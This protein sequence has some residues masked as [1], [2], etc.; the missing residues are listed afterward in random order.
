MAQTKRHFLNIRDQL[1]TNGGQWA[2]SM[3][4]KRDKREERERLLRENF[5]KQY[6]STALD[7]EQPSPSDV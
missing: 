4:S 7:R 5:I 2:D 3:K 6:D 1:V